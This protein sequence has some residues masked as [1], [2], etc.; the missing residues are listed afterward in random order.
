[1][2]RTS[3]LS[4]YSL[5]VD[6][7]VPNGEGGVML[8]FIDA[9]NYLSFSINPAETSY[10]LEQHS[11]GAV[12]VLA[13]GQSEAIASG[14]DAV[15]RLV[16]RLEGNHIELLSNGQRLADLDVS[17]SSDSTRF[18]LLAIGGTA[19]SVALFDNLQIHQIEN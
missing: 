2:Y 1:S 3:P 10:R 6:V 4:D 17:G 5:G 19:D 15:N 16:A 12:R 9:R 18:G 13:G 8:R 14:A 11:G 7:Q